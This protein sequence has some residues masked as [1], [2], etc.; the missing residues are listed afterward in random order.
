MFATRSK[1]LAALVLGSA[2]MAAAAPSL[3]Q[4]PTATSPHRAKM[5]LRLQERLGATDEQMKAIQ[6]VQAKYAD[7]RRQIWQSLR[8]KQQELRQLALNGADQTTIQAKTAEVS[9]LLNQ[10][11]ALR[12]QSL[13]EIS[14][15]LSQEQRDKLAQMGPGMHGRRGDAPRPQGS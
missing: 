13:Q 7:S 4:S 1:W 14:P 10:A 5:M 8:T 6:D 15:L 12:I 9:Q 3:A 2:L 11:L